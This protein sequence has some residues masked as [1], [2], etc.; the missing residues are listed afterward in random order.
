MVGVFEKVKSRQWSAAV[1]NIRINISL[2]YTY[3]EVAWAGV[4]KHL[5]HVYRI[6]AQP[7]EMGQRII[8]AYIN[9]RARGHSAS[10][11]SL[12]F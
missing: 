9:H 12:N 7:F 2:V 3:L 8:G 6:L 4:V 5:L 1:V 10:Q 11:F